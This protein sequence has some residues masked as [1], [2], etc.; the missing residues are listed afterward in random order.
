MD[1]NGEIIAMGFEEVQT[2]LDESNENLKKDNEEFLYKIEINIEFINNLDTNDLKEKICF[3][4]LPDLFNKKD[5]YKQIIAWAT[6]LS[7][8]LTTKNPK[9]Q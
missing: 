3:I 8:A 6:F 4:N 9:Q 2:E 5:V 1:L 7:T